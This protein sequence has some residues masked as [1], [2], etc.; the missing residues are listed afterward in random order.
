MKQRRTPSPSIHFAGR[1]RPSALAAALLAAAPWAT[2]SAGGGRAPKLSSVEI[3]APSP[4]SAELGY[5]DLGHRVWVRTVYREWPRGRPR[6]RVIRFRTLYYLQKPEQGTARLVFE[7]DGVYSRHVL[8]VTPGGGVLLTRYDNNLLLACLARPARRV[9]LKIAGEPAHALIGWADGFLAQPYRLNER[10]PVY[11]VPIVE[12]EPQVAAAVRITAPAGVPVVTGVRHPDRHGF[13]RS[14]R[15]IAWYADGAIHV[16]DLKARKAA[17]A[18]A[19]V[20]TTGR[21]ILKAFDGKLAV[22]DKRVFDA[23][24][25][26]PVGRFRPTVLDWHFAAFRDAV[27]YRVLQHKST[28]RVVADRL[29]RKDR[30]PEVLATFPLFAGRIAGR[31]RAFG[32][33]LLNRLAV[34][35]DADGVRVWNGKQWLLVKWVSAEAARGG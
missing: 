15:R 28:C 29:L 7:M 16:F 30:E 5:A 13:V 11:F 23:A 21:A 27:A 34:L 26:R 8:A 25:G 14:G 31:R 18:S 35:P 24:T 9:P 1:I 4:A 6:P 2:D 10:A 17:T 20:K 3:E 19:E 22:I 32:A 33:D 12:D